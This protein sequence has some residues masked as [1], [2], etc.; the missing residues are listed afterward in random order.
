MIIGIGTDIV[1]VQRIE[2][3]L[4][5]YGKKFYDRILSNGELER[6][7]ALRSS[8]ENTFKNSASFLAKRFAAKEAVSKALGRGI[9]DEYKFKD[10]AILN[11]IKGC[12]YVKL[13]KMNRK[14]NSLLQ[15]LKI[16]LS[17]S[18]DYPIAVAFAIVSMDKIP[19]AQ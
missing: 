6:F 2:R 13:P 7:N 12:P 16:N 4:S 9:G 19:Y 3:V 8:A 1:Q 14:H 11:D 5:I 10:I 15:E 18:D 17:I